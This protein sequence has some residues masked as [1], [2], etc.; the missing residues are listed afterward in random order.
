M[1][2]LFTL[3]FVCFSFNAF[4]CEAEQVKVLADS[5]STLEFATSQPLPLEDVILKSGHDAITEPTEVGSVSPADRAGTVIGLGEPTSQNPKDAGGMSLVGVGPLGGAQTPSVPVEIAARATT[6]T[7]D[8]LEPPMTHA[9]DLAEQDAG[10]RTLAS[11]R[12][13]FL[14][15]PPAAAAEIARPESSE[16]ELPTAEPSPSATVQLGLEVIASMERTLPAGRDVDPNPMAADPQA[17]T[18][19]PDLVFVPAID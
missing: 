4:A 11:S 8:A 15:L 16:R 19:E 14:D 6:A 2:V 3:G 13:N 10:S 1:K 18:R 17:P 5:P 12:P 7:P 9:S